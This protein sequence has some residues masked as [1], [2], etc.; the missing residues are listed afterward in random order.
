MLI[1]VALGLLTLMA[2][3]TFVFDWGVMWVA[4]RQAQNAADSGALAGAVALAF[5]SGAYDN[6]ALKAR[7][8]AAALAQSHDVWGEQPDEAANTVNVTY[9]VTCPDGTDT[10]L[11]VD[12]Y[13]N[14]AHSNPLPMFFGQLVGLTEQG[15]QATAMAQAA[16]AEA[17]D[18]MKPWAI[19]DR[20][21]DNHDETPTIDVGTWTEDDTFDTVVENGNNAGDPLPDADVYTRPGFTLAVDYGRRLQLKVGTPQDAIAPGNFFP[22]ALPLA[23]PH[24]VSSGGDDYRYSIANCNGTPV[25]A[26]Q[27]MTT[28]PGNMVGPTKQGMEE[29]IAADVAMYGESHW[30][31]SIETT[32]PD[33]TIVM[34]NVV[35]AC[36][37][38]CGGPSLRVVAIPVFDPASFVANGR[39]DITIS[40]ILG[41]YLDH[42]DGNDVVGYF[43]TMPGLALGSGPPDID[44]E[45]AFLKVPLLVK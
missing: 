34:G 33:G 24:P 31:P 37:P 9:P 10:C 2:M 30:D 36:D 16:I 8:S 20:W 11:R 15:V 23:E 41:F 14:V 5:D 6:S 19:P 35:R 28:E 7:Q 42:M 27:S 18:C 22:I 38:T 12:V 13:R 40:N 44:P 39:T 21:A 17:S 29:L 32:L 26:G 3:T 25:S 1:Q 4:R 45:A 43:C